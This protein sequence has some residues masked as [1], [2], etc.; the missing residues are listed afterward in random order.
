MTDDKKW[1]TINGAHVPIE[2]GKPQFG[3][4]KQKTRREA[5]TRLRQIAED[6]RKDE[7][8]KEQ[9]KRSNFFD[10]DDSDLE[11]VEIDLTSDIQKQLDNATPEGRA[12]IAYKYIMDNLRGKYPTKDGREVPIERLGAKKMS[13]TLYEPKLRATPE[14]GKLLQ[15]G[16]FMGEENAIKENGEKHKHFDRFVYYK[17]S[18]KI[19]RENYSAILNVGIRPNNTC[20]L[21]DINQFNK[22]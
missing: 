10:E 17:V 18:I 8:F 16:Q 11:T 5:A 6:K 3:G 7:D 15:S 22:K 13:H 14:L 21:Y 19:G 1:V 20:T 4:D 9:G 2:D 12:K